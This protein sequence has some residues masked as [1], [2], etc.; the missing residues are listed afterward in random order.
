LRWTIG[1]SYLLKDQGFGK[2]GRVGNA[3]A[4]LMNEF[5]EVSDNLVARYRDY[6]GDSFAFDETAKFKGDVVAR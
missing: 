6:E 1:C 4:F 2:N 5:L 3:D